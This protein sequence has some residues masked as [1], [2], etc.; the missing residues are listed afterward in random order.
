MTAT[1]GMAAA[2]FAFLFISHRRLCVL[3]NK[4]KVIHCFTPSSVGKRQRARD[5]Q[6]EEIILPADWADHRA[7]LL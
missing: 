5:G 4:E 3:E 2:E 6:N 1:Q 7:P